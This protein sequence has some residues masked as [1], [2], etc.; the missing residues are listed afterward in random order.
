MTCRTKY[1]TCALIFI[2]SGSLMAISQIRE[3][4]NLL[5]GKPAISVTTENQVYFQ[6]DPVNISGSVYDGKGLPVNKSIVTIKVSPS[7]SKQIIIY[8]TSVLAG[9]N[10]TYHDQGLRLSG[11]SGFDFFQLLTPKG[12]TNISKL[13]GQKYNVTAFTVINGVNATAWTGLE[14]KGYFLTFSAIMLYAGLLD[15]LILLIVLAIPAS[16]EKKTRLLIKKILIFLFTSGITLSPIASLSLT[17]SEVGINSP[18]GLIKK[19]IP[20]DQPRNEWVI[21]F[22][23]RVVNDDVLGGVQVPVY[24]FIFGIAGGYLRYLYDTATNWKKELKELDGYNEDTQLFY[25]S[26][27]RLAIIF[28]APLLA[29]AIWFILFQGGTTSNQTLAAVGIAVGLLMKE[30]VETITGFAGGLLK[31]AGDRSKNQQRTEDR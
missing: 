7:D 5:Q 11:S 13:F 28:I 27:E 4:Q 14:I 25:R 15:L 30:V 22:G 24:I 23:G 29:I 2:T 19:H 8:E 9:N 31:S 26:L 12:F 21:N 18:L 6:G 17:D 20:G 1:L 10:G 16:K 3:S